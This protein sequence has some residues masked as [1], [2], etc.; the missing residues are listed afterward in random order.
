MVF[1]ICFFLALQRN[2]AKNVRQ[3]TSS[4][5]NIINTTENVIGSE[6][7]NETNN[8]IGQNKED[9][10]DCLATSTPR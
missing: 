2:A 8:V 7:V 1:F 4:A 10:D 5:L 3:T 9:N 6:N